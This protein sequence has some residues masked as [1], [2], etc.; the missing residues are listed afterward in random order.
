MSFSSEGEGS[1]GEII[2]NPI[3]DVDLPSMKDR[4]VSSND[5]LTVTAHRFST[6]GNRHKKHRQELV[7]FKFWL[8]M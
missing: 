8:L 7:E 6:L 4:F 5:A 2:L 1:D 3:T